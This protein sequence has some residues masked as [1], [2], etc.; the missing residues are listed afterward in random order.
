[1]MRFALAV[2]LL[3]VSVAAAEDKKADRTATPKLAGTW[4]KSVEG[5]EIKFKFEEKTLAVS[6]SSGDNGMTA[7]ADY[8]VDKNGVVK[9]KITKVEEKGDFAA[10]PAKGFEFSMKVAL[11][12]KKATISD[13]TSEHPEAKDIMEGEYVRKD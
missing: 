9:A 13:F 12:D 10:K 4:A 3:A 1:M 5:M 8:T 6:V 7:T 11:K 2:V